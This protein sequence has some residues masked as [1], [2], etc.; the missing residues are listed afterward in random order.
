MS[1]KKEK[2]S[3]I[4]GERTA[5]IS[6]L[7]D[8]DRE[9]VAKLITDLVRVSKENETLKAELRQLKNPAIVRESHS[10][11]PDAELNLVI[12]KDLESEIGKGLEME[13]DVELEDFLRAQR[14]STANSP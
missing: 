10:L 7:C 5:R 1:L 4:K 12:D 13:I 9:K 14:N 11:G 8:E 3:S 6:D 2:S